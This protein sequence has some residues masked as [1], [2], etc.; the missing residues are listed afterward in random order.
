[1]AVGVQPDWI[2]RKSAALEL[3]SNINKKPSIQAEAY[4]RLTSELYEQAL[5]PYREEG[6]TKWGLTLEGES[7]GYYPSVVFKTRLLPLFDITIGYDRRIFDL[8]TDLYLLDYADL[9]TNKL[10]RRL[11]MRQIFENKVKG[12]F[13]VFFEMKST[14][15]IVILMKKMYR[16]FLVLSL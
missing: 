12:L 14:K 8:I 7:I 2:C 16:N 10:K 6:A 15:I 11:T 13:D 1:M 4:T 3:F 5:G 9:I